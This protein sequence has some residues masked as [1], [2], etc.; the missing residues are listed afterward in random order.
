MLKKGAVG[1]RVKLLQRLLD[2]CGFDLGK[3]GTNKDGV[4]GEFGA[5]TEDAVKK[6]Q[7]RRGLAVDGIVG[8]QTWKKL[9]GVAN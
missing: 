9:L 2:N 5:K 3:T 4:D 1:A 7:V 8:V 6:Y